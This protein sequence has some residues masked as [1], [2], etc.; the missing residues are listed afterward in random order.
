MT[1][2]HGPSSQ[3]KTHTPGVVLMVCQA[4]HP[5]AELVRTD[6]LALM[7][8]FFFCLHNKS[9]IKITAVPE[10][11]TSRY[12]QNNITSEVGSKNNE[13]TPILLSH[14]T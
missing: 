1:C 5:A 9:S 6:T 14:P 10:R 12:S 2:Q 3:T 4:S 7:F 11:L 8:L 13:S